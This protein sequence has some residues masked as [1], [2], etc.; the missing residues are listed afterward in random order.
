M[1][2]VDEDFSVQ[3]VNNTEWGFSG[4]WIGTGLDGDQVIIPQEDIDDYVEVSFPKIDKLAMAKGYEEMAE[5]NLEEAEASVHTYN[6]G[7]IK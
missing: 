7:E 2:Q 6:D 4:D 5:I 3:K 1:S